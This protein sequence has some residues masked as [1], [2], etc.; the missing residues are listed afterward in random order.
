MNRRTFF[1]S[2][3]GLA[4]CTAAHPRLNVFNWS[5]Y[6]ASDTIQRF[7]AE[8]GVSVR[9]AIYESNE[10]ML[11]RV[12]SGNSGWDVVFPTHY[13]AVPMREMGLL[14]DLHH[15]WL[16][17]LRNLASQFQRP[18]WDP[19]IQFTVPY[20]W[21]ASGIL[22]D[23]ARTS[24]LSRWSD[25]WNP[26]LQGQ[27]TMLDDPS[28]VIG[29]ALMK[30]GLPLNATAVTE[31]DRAKAEA[32][33]Q[34]PLLRAYLNAEVRDQVVSGDI[35]A[36]QLWATTAQ[37]ALDA[38]PRLRWCYPQEGFALYADCAVILRESHRPE[39]AHRFIN[40]LLRADVAARIVTESR[41][42]TANEAA[43]ALLSKQVASL[44]TLYPS[45]ETLARGQW[46]APMPAPAQRLRDRIWTEIKSA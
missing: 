19:R 17:N 5:N 26:A 9:Y 29:A 28:E 27:I 34:K 31:L 33:Q 8:S 23:P 7:E 14:D 10:E 2:L 3:S 45:A 35:A 38:A 15:Q 42:A 36:A 11:A 43:Q 30:I 4:G 41:T 39:L 21:G 44:S 6:I 13:F 20:M 22:Y 37:Q 24:T 16:P 46:F 40:Y 18:H 25:L 32:V 1:L 12:M